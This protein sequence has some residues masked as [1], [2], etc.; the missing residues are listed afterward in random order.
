MYPLHHEPF[1]SWCHLNDEA[2]TLVRLIPGARQVSGSQSDDEK[3][4]LLQAFCEGQLRV[5]I[6]KP[7]IAG[8][9]LNLQHCAHLSVFPSHSYEQYYQAVRRCWRYGQ[10]RPVVVDVVSTA[11]EG[12]V[13]GNLQRKAEAADRMFTALVDHMRDALHVHLPSYVNQTPHVPEW[14]T[15]IGV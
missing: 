2:D 11:G 14:L 3:E 9:G 15:S 12:N 8:F 6:T 4:E 10:T 5:L 7:R 1:L 13:L